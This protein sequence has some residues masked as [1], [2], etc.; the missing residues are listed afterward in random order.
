MNKDY[1]ID[2]L[3]KFVDVVRFLMKDEQK[4]NALY[5]ELFSLRDYFK[6]AVSEIHTQEENLAKM[7]NGEHKNFATNEE[8]QESEIKIFS[9]AISSYGHMRTCLHFT[10]MICKKENNPQL[11]AI[12][13]KYKEWAK[14]LV[15]K[16]DRIQAHPHEEW[17]IAGEAYG[18]NSNGEVYFS[19]RDFTNSGKSRK[20]TLTP[21][22]DLEI[23]KNYLKE[24]SMYF[25]N[26]LS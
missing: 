2:S 18:R 15:D 9:C 16:R 13:E 25:I 14:N 6:Y 21:R 5:I 12:R 10:K 7:E 24:V 19:T 23:L 22:K 1:E 17:A 26:L 4:F 3:N 8:Y 20:I 11:L